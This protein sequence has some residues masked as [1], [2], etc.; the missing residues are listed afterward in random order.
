[1]PPLRCRP[2]D[3]NSNPAPR[4]EAESG[5][6][7]AMTALL[8]QS[9]KHTSEMALI[10]KGPARPTEFVRPKIAHG[11]YR[12]PLTLNT[13][14]NLLPYDRKLLPPQVIYSLPKPHNLHIVVSP[15]AQ[16]LA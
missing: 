6:I 3:R 5:P 12:P 9:I 4:L 13:H 15:E 8:S 10:R 1:M 14:A 16:K 2:H 11:P 7:S